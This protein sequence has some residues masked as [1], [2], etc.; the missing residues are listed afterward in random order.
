MNLL[1]L[2]L[3]TFHLESSDG[4]CIAGMGFWGWLFTLVIGGMILYGVMLYIVAKIDEKHEKKVQF[5]ID[6]FEKDMKLD[7]NVSTIEGTNFMGSHLKLYYN[8]I[9]HNVI[10]VDFTTKAHYDKEIENFD[11]DQYVINSTSCC[12]LDERQRLLL[13][14]NAGGMLRGADVVP[15]PAVTDKSEQMV[16]ME[17]VNFSPFIFDMPTKQLLIVQTTSFRAYP[18]EAMPSEISQYGYDKAFIF[19]DQLNKLFFADK[20]E[21]SDYNYSDIHIALDTYDRYSSVSTTHTY[22]HHEE[23]KTLNAFTELAF[24][25]K[26]YTK[27][28]THKKIT[29]SVYSNSDLL[30]EVRIGDKILKKGEIFNFYEGSRLKGDVYQFS[31]FNHGKIHDILQTE[32]G[33]VKSLL[34]RCYGQGNFVVGRLPFNNDEIYNFMVE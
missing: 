12:A 30:I 23:N 28:T 17:N 34:I 1:L 26:E 4:L 9:K 31:E 20:S 27:V 10:V 29:D 19:F 3:Q 32:L 7:E 24:N 13:I 25:Y 16:K 33:K 18:I 15:M 21:L 22:T 8:K 2:T 6:E 11:I 14:A 5:Q